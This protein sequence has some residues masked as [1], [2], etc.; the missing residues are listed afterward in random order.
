MSDPLASIPL[1]AVRVF[2][3]AARLGSFTRAAE[4]LGMT[5][6]AVSWQVKALE[7]RLDQA[8]FRRLPREVALTAAGER[9]ARAATEAMGSLRSALSDITGK[10]EGVLAISTLQTVAMQWLAPRLGAFQVAHPQIAVRVE[11]DNRIVDLLREEVD[12]AIRGGQ[13][14]WPGLEALPLFPAVQTVLAAPELVARLG[15]LASPGDVR[16]VPRIGAAWEWALWFQ[17]AGV[18]PPQDA[19]GA[20][21]RLAGDTQTLEV[22]AALAGHGVALASPILFAGE[23][24][25]GRLVQPFDVTVQM[26]STY[27]L[28]YPKDRRKT[29]KIAAFREWLLAAVAADPAVQRYAGLS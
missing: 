14:E 12:V 25:S 4:E 26:G 3:A 7:Q 28:V 24:A 10:G 19:A 21:P 8:L 17:A 1:S 15:G 2:E 5:Q 18:E 27:W 16:D 20:A 23:I 22:A 9:L 29:R 6:A 13:G 11:T